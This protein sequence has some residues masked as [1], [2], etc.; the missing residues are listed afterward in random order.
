MTVLL[1]SRELA[2][3]LHALRSM[4]SNLRDD[5]PDACSESCEHFTDADP[6]TSDE[7]D[8]LCENLNCSDQHGDGDG[9]AQC[10]DRGDA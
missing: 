8:V 3:I 7:I 5:I 6:L 2:T 4:Q 9:G 1:N 10:C